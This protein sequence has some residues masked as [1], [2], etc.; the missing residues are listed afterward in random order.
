[1]INLQNKTEQTQV[2][3]PATTQT[4]QENF[5]LA[6]CRQ[7]YIDDFEKTGELEKYTAKI[8]VFDPN[9]IVKFGSE[10][11]EEVSKSADVV[12]NGMNMDQIN[13]SGKML[14]ALDKIMGSFDIDEIK[15]DKGL[16]GKLFGNAKKKLEKLLNKYNTMGDEIDK[17]YTQL[18]VYEGEIEKANRNLDQ[19]FNS[20]LEY[21][22]ELVK[23][24]A[25]GEQGCKELHEY[26][27]QKEQELATSNNVDLQ[28][29]ISNL[30]QAENMLEQRVMDLKTAESIA[31]QS[32]PMIKTMEFSNANLTRKINSAFIVTLPVFKQA[33]A[34][35]MMLKRQKIQADSMSA[36]DK[37]T[38]ELLIKN[39][40]NTVEQSK[41]ITR[42]TNTSSVQIETL[43]K[44]WNTIVSGIDET[45]R[46]QEEAKRKR[47]EDSKRLDVIKQQYAEKMK[48]L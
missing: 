30:R 13:N 35:A 23:Y 27:E 12:L 42:M 24:I 18:K 19:M 25:A 7:G 5:S 26:I 45:K 31:L 33:L 10:A 17:I 4:P 39:A 48:G 11:A 22:H 6:E 20:N 36:L 14:E 47:E 32:I 9:S 3:A 44:T 1:M 21:Y 38:N 29:E 46:I 28:F 8:E 40:Q 16:F 37:R 15:E 43:E 34:Q 2:A 41:Q